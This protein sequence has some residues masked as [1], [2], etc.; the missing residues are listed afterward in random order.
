[1]EIKLKIH[2]LEKRYD[3]G[4]VR[5]ENGKNVKECVDY[6]LDMYE[7][8]NLP[9]TTKLFQYSIIHINSK[10]ADKHSTIKDGDKVMITP[11][12]KDG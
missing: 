10:I 8:I 6:I 4:T 2:T 3:F 9:D 12:I 7:Q 5:I 11:Q 1:M